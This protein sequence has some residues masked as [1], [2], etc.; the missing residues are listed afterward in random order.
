MTLADL[1]LLFLRLVVGLTFAGHGAQKL[2]GWW[3]GPGLENWQKAVAGMRFQPVGLW[4]A[5]SIVAELIGGLLLAIGFL[6]PF[7]AAILVAQTVVIILKAHLPNGFWNTRKGYEYPLAL[8]AA[9]VAILGIGPGPISVDGAI[10][11]E[12]ATPV[13]WG[14]LVLGLLAGLASYGLT[15]LSGERQPATQQ[16]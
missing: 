8:G 9:T 2:L 6:T 14:L 15:Q 13:L 4:T 11:L 12:L 7:A 5:A 3:G 16:R 1:S 10:G